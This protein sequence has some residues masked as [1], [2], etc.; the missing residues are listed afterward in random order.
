MIQMRY[1]F[2]YIIEQDEDGYYIA[3]V[4]EL[5]DCHTQ[6]KSLDELNDRITEAINLYFIVE[7]FMEGA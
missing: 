6:V 5:P 7:E 2:P 3:D 4:P 1:T